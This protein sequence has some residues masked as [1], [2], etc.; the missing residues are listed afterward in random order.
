MTLKQS[1]CQLLKAVI[2]VAG[3]NLPACGAPA[4]IE[5]GLPMGMVWICTP[6][7][8]KLEPRE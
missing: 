4:F 6:H 2:S 7:Y 3:L 1:T 5:M 8:A